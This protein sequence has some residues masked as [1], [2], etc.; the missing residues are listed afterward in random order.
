MFTVQALDFIDATGAGGG[1]REELERWYG[2]GR[3][4]IGHALIVEALH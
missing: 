4:S 1:G 3:C 2:D